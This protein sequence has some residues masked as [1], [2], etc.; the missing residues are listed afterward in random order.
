MKPLA[1]SVDSVAHAAGVMLTHGDRA[2]FLKRSD[3][4]R[5]HAGEWCCPGGSIEGGETPEQ[6]AAR[7]LTEET[8][9]TAGDFS[10]LDDGDGF[11]TFRQA[12]SEESAPTLN[13]EHTEFQWAAINEPPQPL[14]PGVASTLKK[15]AE[16][17]GLSALELDAAADGA[18]APAAMALD[19]RE[20]DDNG[21]FEVLDNPISTVGVYQYNEAS[22]I[23][24][25][26]PNKMVGVYRS[27]EELGNA[28][29]VN[30]FRLM[31][32]TDDHP[33]ALLGDESKGFVPAEKKG[34]HGVIGEKVYFDHPTLYGNLK[35]FSESLSG[36]LP[37]K[38]ELSCGY[39]CKF[40]RQDG[41]YEGQPYEYVQTRIRGNHISSVPA[42]RMGAAV[43]VQDAAEP[44]YLTFSLD[45]QEQ[46][47]IATQRVAGDDSAAAKGTF[48][49]I[50]ESTT[51]EESVMPKS[52]T[53]AKGDVVD[54]VKKT[55]SPD[56]LASPGA[57]D[58]MPDEG[59]DA[60]EDD[61]DKMEAAKDADEEK[62]DKDK[63]D[64]E[65]RDRKSARDRRAGARDARASARDSRKGARD[66]MAKDA[67]DAAAAAAAGKGMDAAA[68]TEIVNAAV[69]KV[70]VPTVA[71]MI[72]QVG[73]VI[74]REEAAKVGIYGRVSPL[75]GAFDHAEMTHE[76]MATYALDKLGAPKPPAGVDPTAALD[77]YLAGRTQ[78][79]TPMHQGMD[80]AANSS[81][82]LEAYLASTT[83]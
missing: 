68:V 16:A 3:K 40:V 25:G 42:G 39:H 56:D 5:D 51:E 27:A 22:V 21:W 77:F 19:R 44:A 48:G 69:A 81:P 24:D 12:V 52:A 59:M 58:G 72:A 31:P 41:V 46:L 47:L 2:L 14:H 13:E 11:I 64:K 54:P 62:S 15:M 28:D 23:A 45:M 66:K 57:K 4:S 7:E 63:D 53:D 83:A 6:A 43:A 18:K 34:V 55:N 71:E 38:R 80:A 49:H 61:A 26:D 65:A 37:G 1:F 74:R 30:S 78:V 8:G 35:I 32:W 82:A 60:K 73:P 79:L 50:G 20:Y 75:I 76:Q 10:R 9:L 33:E 29:T 17:S 36:K 67:R 70:K